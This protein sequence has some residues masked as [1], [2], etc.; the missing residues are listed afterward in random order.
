VGRSEK[1]VLL[2]DFQL[3]GL[4]T[5]HQLTISESGKMAALG[6]PH[7]Q[8][9]SVYTFDFL[10]HTNR[11]QVNLE[12]DVPYYGSHIYIDRHAKTLIVGSK[13]VSVYEYEGRGEWTHVRDF[14]KSD[15][16]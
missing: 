12:S 16:V 5:P 4:D 11:F 15:G 7:V 8:G 6:L 1:P 9:G 2:G 10:E 3:S 13:H 14:L